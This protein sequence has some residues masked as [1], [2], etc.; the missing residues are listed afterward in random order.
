MNYEQ[1]FYWLE[2]Y[3]SAFGENDITPTI[4]EK[5]ASVKGVQQFDSISEG[6]LQ[7]LPSLSGIKNKPVL[8]ELQEMENFLSKYEDLPIEELPT[9]TELPV[10]D[11]N[12][13][14]EV[15]DDTAE[16]LKSD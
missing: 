14:W 13:K 5:M 1:F 3:I 15:D 10:G 11:P 2:G 4:V 9:A 7:S 6:E 16:E 8:P 12:A